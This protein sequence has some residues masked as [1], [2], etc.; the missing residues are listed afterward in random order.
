MKYIFYISFL[1]FVSGSFAQ[2][3]KFENFQQEFFIEN[4]GQWA[5]DL[6]YMLEYPGTEVLVGNNK[7]GYVLTNEED[8]NQHNQH[9]HFTTTHEKVSEPGIIHQHYVEVAFN[10]ANPFPIITGFE[11][12]ITKINY[13]IGNEEDRWATDIRP[14][15]GILYEELYERTDLKFYAGDK[16]LKYEFIV[17]P[18]GKPKDISFTYSGADELYLDA[19]GKLHIRTSLGDFYEEPPYVYQEIKGEIYPIPAR[20]KLKKNTV[21]FDLQAPHNDNFDLIID[22]QLIFCSY[23][24]S[25]ADNWGNTA[26]VDLDGSLYSGG[27]VFPSNGGIGRRYRDE[28]SG[29]PTTPGAFQTRFQGGNTDIGILKFDSTGTSLLYA[30][31]L[32]GNDTELPS[33]MVADKDGFLYV[34]GVT[35]SFDYPVSTSTY[36]RSFNGGSPLDAGDL[37]NGHTFR[38]GVDLVITKLNQSGTAIV[39]ST[40]VGGSG[41]EGILEYSRGL[42]N[43]YGDHLRGDINVTDDG[44][45]YVASSTTGS[46]PVK[47]AI[48]STYGGGG[49]DALAFKMTDDLSTMVWATYLGGVSDDGSYG[50]TLD[51]DNNVYVTGGTRSSNFPTTAGAYRTN[52]LGNVDGF[53]SLIDKDGNTLMSS[54]RLGTSSFDQAYFVQLDD[55]GSPHILGQTKGV[56]SVTPGVYS[57]LFSGIFIHKLSPDLSSSIWSTVVGSGSFVPDISPTAFLVNECG[58]ILLSGWGGL[59]NSGYNGGN[60]NGMPVTEN[61]FRSGTDGNDFYLMSLSKNAEELLYATFFGAAGGAADHVDGGTS[62]FDKRGIVYQSICASCGGDGKS[63]TDPSRLPTFPDNV[64]SATNRSFGCNNGVFKFDLSNLRADFEVEDTCT[65]KS[66]IFK[67]LSLAGVE[68]IWDFGD[69]NKYETNTKE[70]VYH[71]YAE[72]GT[73]EA[74][75]IAIDEA[76][77]KKA[78][79]LCKTL[80]V[81]F[82]DDNRY[83]Q[84]TVCV[85]ESI[86]LE[87]TRDPSGTKDYL[88]LPPDYLD[89]NTKETP[90]STPLEDIKYI[91]EITDTSGCVQKDSLDLYVDEIIPDFKVQVLGN[92]QGLPKVCINNNIK[93]FNPKTYEWKS[94]T[95][96]STDDAPCHVFDDYGVK[97]FEISIATPYCSLDTTASV[98]LEEVEIPNIFT[99]NADSKNDVFFIS[100]LNDSGDWSVQI[101]NRWGN[102]VFM[103]EEYSNNWSAENQNDGVYYYRVVSPEGKECKGWVQVIR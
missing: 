78:D 8:L 10:N 25:R 98:T 3:I 102:Q 52:A 99:P 101:F 58:N 76:T 85:G 34:L 59:L 71:T 31:Y 57:N 28:P 5:E 53:V 23:S 51:A 89:D 1:C 92:C 90:V 86:Q 16:G 100:G 72:Y 73:Y 63:T 62:R 38:N 26:C 61:A 11:K 24:G 56:Y 96:T 49:T 18:G 70:T 20:F 9:E 65:E 54:T 88:W 47:N 97:N 29:F 64:V 94:G 55:E 27:T 7:I 22:P 14:S 30:T 36:D 35:S 87:V 39:S 91:V 103:D 42:A 37:I 2:Q 84:D 4:K 67:N 33:S 69:G 46:F 95:W 68:F 50:L 13:L 48:Q 17:K 32:G 40:F 45:I 79:T 15:K 6:R 75:L 81:V 83:F 66:V 19:D 77:C 43:N 74:C 12:E 82:P 93:G 41:N 44:F 80:Y 60:T 21:S